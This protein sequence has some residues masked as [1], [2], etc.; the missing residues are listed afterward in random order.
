MA[1]SIAE[2]TMGKMPEVSARGIKRT[3][4]SMVAVYHKM[5]DANPLASLHF[6]DLIGF[7]HAAKSKIFLLIDPEKM[8]KSK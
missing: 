4:D 5:I 3:G 1:A 2:L 7:I 8:Y 6:E